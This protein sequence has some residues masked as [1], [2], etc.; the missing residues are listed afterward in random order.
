MYVHVISKVLIL[1]PVC[2][3]DFYDSIYGSVL[4]LK[5]IRGKRLQSIL[6]AL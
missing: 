6:I 4:G 1:K 2:T 5:T 3:T